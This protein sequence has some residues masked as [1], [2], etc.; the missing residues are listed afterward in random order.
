[1]TVRDLLIFIAALGATLVSA[2]DIQARTSA[3]QAGGVLELDGGPSL[4]RL[5]QAARL[6]RL[7]SVRV[8]TLSLYA[9]GRVPEPEGLSRPEL[10]K[11]LRVDVQYDPGL[12]PRVP[13]DWRRELVPSLNPAAV[14][15]LARA[16]AALQTGDVLIV[17][18]VPERGTSIRLNRHRIVAEG[19]HDVMLAF[20]DHWLGQRPVSQDVKTALVAGFRAP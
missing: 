4:T 19:E 17:S 18:Y 8:Y 6:E 13:I 3:G 12:R 15:S 10:A 20:L 9:S 2:C 16:T 11:A 5:A 14:A 1:V 7:G